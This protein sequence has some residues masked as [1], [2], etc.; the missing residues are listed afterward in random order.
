MTS[1]TLQFLGL[2]KKAGAIVY[3]DALMEA[4]R[5]HSVYIVLLS[6]CASERTKK[7]IKDKCAFYQIK[8]FEHIEGDVFTGIKGKT[9]AAFGIDNQ[10][11]ASK[12]VRDEKR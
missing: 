3:G 2:V 12:I 4:I 9:V 1:S 11:M 10:K 6:D 5:N 7:Q 8:L